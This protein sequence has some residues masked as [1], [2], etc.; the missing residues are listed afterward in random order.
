MLMLPV[1]L[2][3]PVGMAVP[4][5]VVSVVSV[6][7]PAVIRSVWRVA[8]VAVGTPRVLP[9]V[10]VV[11]VAWASAGIRAS[12]VAVVAAGI[13]LPGWA[14]PVATAVT[15]WRRASADWPRA[16]MVATVA[17]S[18][19]VMVEPAV[20]RPHP[21]ARRFRARMAPVPSRTELP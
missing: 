3:A 17:G 1:V 12:V 19:V 15:R 21:M 7:M 5:L 4:A 20:L 6:V 9:V 18:P 14:V 2:V 8:V 16:V 13:A 10:S 11:L